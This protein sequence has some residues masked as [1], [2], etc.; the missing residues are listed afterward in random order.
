MTEL[1]GSP[2][3]TELGHKI[4]YHRLT[5]NPGRKVNPKFKYSVPA[6]S[7]NWEVQINWMVTQ[8]GEIGVGWDYH[9]TKFWFTN[10]QDKLMFVLMWT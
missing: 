6:S 5:K 2:N 1:N 10:E 7:T 8:Y 9:R 3:N 4:P